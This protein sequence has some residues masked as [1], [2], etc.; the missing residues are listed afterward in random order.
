[1]GLWF[2]PVLFLCSLLLIPTSALEKRWSWMGEA[3]LLAIF[4]IVNFIP[5]D[6]VGLM[7][8]KYFFFFFAVGYLLAKHR[9]SIQ[10]IGE[11][12]INVLLAGLSVLFLALFVILYQVG[13]IKPYDFPVTL[14]NLFKSPGP[15]LI[16]Y[17]MAFLGIALAVAVVKASGSTRARMA[18]AWFG[19]VTMDI[20]VAHG[21]MIQLAFGSGWLKVLTGFVFGVVLS[22]ALSFIL[23]R[24]WW[25]SAM[26]FLGI[27][28]RKPAPAAAPVPEEAP[29][30]GPVE[31]PPET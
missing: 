15:Y 5:V 10:R 8:V 26:V 16:R 2:L 17:S 24:Q 27:K 31:A 23:L 19:L 28:R 12:R 14:G 18:L 3:S 7:Q 21:L 22:L 20:Y 4:I 9:K 29:V 13:R 6:I 11:N 1:V 30:A 25:V